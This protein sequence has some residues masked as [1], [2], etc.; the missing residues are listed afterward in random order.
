MAA[1]LGQRQTPRN[2]PP[3]ALARLGAS[4]LDSSSATF[5]RLG[6]ARLPPP[7]THPRRTRAARRLPRREL[8]WAS[9]YASRDRNAAVPPSAEG[10]GG[11]DA[12]SIRINKCFRHFASRREA[13]RFVED[14]RV[15]IDGVKATPG[16]RV[17]PGARVTLDGEVVH[18]E[19][20]NVLPGEAI[21]THP[22]SEG[23]GASGIAFAPFNTPRTHGTVDAC[24]PTR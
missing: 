11:D 24:V 20:L 10:E 21:T 17:S 23:A 18:W 2:A 4:R 8:C 5:N 16:C 19:R 14:G 1:F 9:G 15:E 12:P 6:S 7:C 3:C 22:T 13:D